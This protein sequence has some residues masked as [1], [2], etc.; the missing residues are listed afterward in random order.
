[1][2]CVLHI[3]YFPFPN[4]TECKVA[5]QKKERN[6][7]ADGYVSYVMCAQQQNH[8]HI[9]TLAQAARKLKNLT[10]A[11]SRLVSRAACGMEVAA[12]FW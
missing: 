5:A 11:R 12:H 2:C 1:M 7:T 6:R 10:F 8:N 4:Q 3:I 9:Y